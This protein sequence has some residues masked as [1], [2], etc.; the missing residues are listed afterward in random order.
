M[1]SAQ[2]DAYEAEAQTFRG[3]FHLANPDHAV[4]RGRWVALEHF[5]EQHNDDVTNQK[6]KEGI[7]RHHPSSR[8]QA[9]ETSVEQ[10]D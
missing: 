8:G 10:S 7:V 5:K 1:E 2:R 9:S 4:V 3:V 6:E